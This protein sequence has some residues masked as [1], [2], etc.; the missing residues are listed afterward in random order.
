MRRED[1]RTLKEDRD[2]KEQAVLG[3]ATSR[4]KDLGSGSCEEGEEGL[5]YLLSFRS[6]P[7]TESLLGANPLL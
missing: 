4:R 2:I 6:K 7:S 3:A 5:S 1:L